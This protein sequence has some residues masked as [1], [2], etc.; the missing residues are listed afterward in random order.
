MRRVV[1]LLLTGSSFQVALSGMAPGRA[2][3]DRPNIIIIN[4]DD[5][6]YG[7]LTVTGAQGY[8]T[9]NIDRLSFDGI[10]FTQ[11]YSPSAVSSASRAGLMTG[12]YPNRI[13]IY[14]ALKPGTGIGVN[15]SETFI[16]NILKELGYVTAA[17]GKWHLGDDYEFLPLQRGFDE[18]FGLPYSNDMWPYGYMVKPGE[19]QT[20]R[21]MDRPELPL[22]DGNNVVR[23]IK[24]M[25]DQDELTT[26]YTERAVDFISRSRKRP[27]FLYFAHTMVH[28]P[29]AVSD[30]FRGKSEQGLFGDAMMEVDWSVGQIVDA[31]RRIGA[32]KNT[33]IIFTSDNGPWMNFGARA[34]S[35]AGLREAKHVTF[36]GGQRVPCIMK[37]PGKIPQGAI[38]NRM[39]GAIDILPTIAAI[40]GGS[41][42]E[43][44]IDG[45][46]IF[47][48]ML[49]D[50]SY[51]AHEYLYYY[52]QNNQLDAVRD[53]RFKLVEPHKYVSYEGMLPHDDGSSGKRCTRQ[54][55]WA[56]YDLR[57]DPGERYDVKE[58]YPEV[59]ERLQKAL[60]AMRQECG[61]SN[62]DVIGTEVRPAGIAAS[63]QPRPQAPA[64]VCR[65]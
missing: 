40:T 29:L 9:P 7:D 56:L 65:E 24:S 61:D 19:I 36:E 59:V 10:R 22:Y 63:T 20:E 35:S 50:N 51:R 30:R 43:N 41:L 39:C 15:T 37:W 52:V 6:G 44:K 48:L 1:T 55:D 45:K 64:P 8:S 60:D 4:M 11:F 3:D 23:Y 18:Y 46:N 2:G 31:V 33:L 32:E 57:R 53:D 16:S 14:G 28:V 62:M 25:D 38:C 12:C 13:S 49:G 27:F 42:P 47:P 17:V 58:M 5:M 21:V 34:G 54:T 26:L